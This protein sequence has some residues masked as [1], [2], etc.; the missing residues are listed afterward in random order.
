MEDIRKVSEALIF[1][2]RYSDYLCRKAWGKALIMWGI[3]AP[4]G[5]LLYFNR[6]PLSNL[7]N[8]G[9]ETFSIL[10]TATVALIG[11]GM[12]FYIFTSASRLLETKKEKTVSSPKES[13]MHGI[14]IGFIWFLL[15]SLASLLPEPL[16]VISSL[17]AGGFAIIMSFLILKKFHDTYTE[18][19]IVGMLLLISSIPLFI[20]VLTDIELA[21]I[22]TVIISSI[23]FLAGGY[24]S[25]TNAAKILSGKG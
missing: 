12:T 14:I 5:L 6:Q 20:L 21:R 2:E 23:S 15:F 25:F 11:V 17:W 3:M 19:L 9:I 7:F 4:I 18:L 24:Y 8:M 13:S 22:G 16:S 1:I 10:T